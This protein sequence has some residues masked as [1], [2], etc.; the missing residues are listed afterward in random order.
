M[1][2]MKLGGSVVPPLRAARVMIDAS[3]VGDSG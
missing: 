3:R 1:S 2:S